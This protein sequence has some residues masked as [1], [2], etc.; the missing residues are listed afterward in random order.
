MD[1]PLADKR[2]LG[3]FAQ[4]ADGGSREI[5]VHLNKSIPEDMH[6]EAISA[7]EF[8][9]QSAGVSI[10]NIRVGPDGVNNSVNI[11]VDA[12]SVMLDEVQSG[13]SASMAEMEDSGLRGYRVESIEVAF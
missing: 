4:S 11:S 10:S 7:F 3:P 9:M 2:P 13:A 5:F 12:N 1:R 8:H 6:E